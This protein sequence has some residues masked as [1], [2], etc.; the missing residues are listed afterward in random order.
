MTQISDEVLNV[1]CMWG[2]YWRNLDF[3]LIVWPRETNR[4]VCS[5]ICVLSST[6]VWLD[7]VSVL[8][9]LCVLENVCSK[10]DQCLS[11]SCSLTM[12]QLY[13]KERDGDGFL[14]MAYSGENTFG[15]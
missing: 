15:F 10:C 9:L 7:D 2:M 3:Q 5:C 8:N 1:Y 12:G 4:G 14:Y 13:E 11:L 6:F